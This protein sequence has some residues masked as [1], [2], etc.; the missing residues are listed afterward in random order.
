MLTIKELNRKVSGIKKSA[1]TIRDNVQVV[2]VNASAHAYEHGDVTVFTKLFD[3]TTGLSKERIV[4]W[5]HDYGFA[6]LQKDGTFRVN[7]KMRTES[8][9]SNG[10]EVVKYLT[11]NAPKWYDNEKSAEQILKELDVTSRIASL[12][13]AITKAEEKGQKINSEDADV[14]LRILQEK[15][16]QI[17]A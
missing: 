3:A 5:V 6:R 8:D 15:I 4:K 14:A 13:K 9:F 10:E 12:T 11:E 2:L 7:K 16:E 17:E 1:T